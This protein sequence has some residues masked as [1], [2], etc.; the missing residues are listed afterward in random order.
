MDDGQ[1][2]FPGTTGCTSLPGGL[3]PTFAAQDNV[4]ILNN[5]MTNWCDPWLASLQGSGQGVQEQNWEVSGNTLDQ[6]G[7]FF[8]G[9]GFGS[10]MRVNV[11]PTAGDPPQFWTG[12]WL[13]T[14]NT[15]NGT[16]GAVASAGCSGGTT[17]ESASFGA[18]VNVT[19]EDNNF[20]INTSICGGTP[21]LQ[22]VNN[23]GNG[24]NTHLVI[25]NN[26][27]PGAT[28]VAAP[29]FGGASNP[30]YI[31]CGNTGQ[32]SGPDPRC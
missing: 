25:K 5:T 29:G 13:I 11:H 10:F 27:F 18:T 21:F 4:R 12:N 26:K 19:I 6:T 14:H 7:C 2:V 23:A 17:G 16:L 9:G 3:C 22:F 8:G 24:P 32:A 1:T 20:P 28:R 15:V 30:G 31:Q